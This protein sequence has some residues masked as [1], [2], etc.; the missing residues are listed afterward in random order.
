MSQQNPNEWNTEPAHS[1]W[2]E[3][4]AW[5][6][7]SATPAEN[8]T[9]EFFATEQFAQETYA[10]QQ[11]SGGKG[12]KIAL[13][14]AVVLI[15]ALAAVL[16]W[17]LFFQDKGDDVT[18]AVAAATS[19][20]SAVASEE[21]EESETTTIDAAEETPAEPQPAEEVVQEDAPDTV[22]MTTTVTAPQ[23]APQQS[24]SDICDGRGVLIIASE[25]SY[26][27]AQAAAASNPGSQ[28]LSPGQCPSLRAR[29]DGNDVYPVI[30]DYGSNLSALCQA[31]ARGGGNA[32]IL[33]YTQNWNS[34]C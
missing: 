6:N 32:R 13:L 3:N 28:V 14:I 24:S 5:E 11:P 2:Q 31:E 25:Y 22:V 23:N 12:V 10:P 4:N 30:V 1:Q 26:S 9:Q 19:E 33:N 34:P 29:Y 17:L 18:D 16:S 20:T 15:V 8:P 27:S 7:P 21:T